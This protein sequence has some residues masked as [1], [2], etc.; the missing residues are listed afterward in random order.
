MQIRNPP[1]PQTATL[2]RDLNQKIG[3]QVRVPRRR[4]ERREAVEVEQLGEEGRRGGEAGEQEG[5]GG[6]GVG[7]VLGGKGVE[8]D[9]AG[10]V[11]IRGFGFVGVGIGVIG[12]IG[13]SGGGGGGK[14][15]ARRVDEF[16]FIVELDL[17]QGGS[18]AGLGADWTRAGGRVV[19]AAQT[20]SEGVD[21]GGLAD[22]R[23]ADDADGDGA[24]KL[25]G[26]GVAL[27]GAEEGFA[28]L[29]G[30]EV[31]VLEG[32]GVG[33]R[34]RGAEREG[35]EVAAEVDE[36]GLEHGRGDEVD[37]VEDQDQA[38]AAAFGR[39][40]LPLDFLAARALRVARVEDVQ[41][42]VGGGGDGLEDLVEGAARGFRAGRCHGDGGVA[43]G[44]VLVAVGGRVVFVHF[45]CATAG[46]FAVELHGS[47]SGGC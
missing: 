38:F 15:D 27:Q 44:G 42:D 11:V 19:L 16:E 29:L 3:R 5:D 32:L 21:D 14:D 28:R 20:G 13:G 37:F 1:L 41:D 47:G 12:V 43:D 36:P 7:D 31:F 45:V 33:R 10:L 8:E 4:H 34:V 24:L 22:V 25:F 2:P 35:R 9:E 30:G 39:H 6:E 18:D 17:A 26:V 46:F 40:D 23:I